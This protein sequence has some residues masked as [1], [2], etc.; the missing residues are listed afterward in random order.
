MSITIADSLANP[1]IVCMGEH[2]VQP[3][4]PSHALIHGQLRDET[5]IVDDAAQE[6]AHEPYAPGARGKF[7][8][9]EGQWTK[10]SLIEKIKH[11]AQRR[12][13]AKTPP[14]S[15]MNPWADLATVMTDDDQGGTNDIE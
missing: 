2:H 13:R 12:Q 1:H 7:Q 15:S 11:E 6:D 8:P 10:T 14:L 5:P 3:E 4:E 9:P